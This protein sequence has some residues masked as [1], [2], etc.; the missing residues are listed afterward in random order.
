MNKEILRLAIPNIITNL[1][2]PLVSLVDLALMGRMPSTA[3][4]LAMGFGTV[5][6]NFIYWAFGFLRMGTTGMVSQAYGKSDNNTS[7]D[8]LIKGLSIAF[9][10][11]LLMI[12]FQYPLKE[13]ALFLI[14]PES[15][16]VAPLSTYFNYRI[17]AAPATISLFVI[18]GWL[19]GMQNAKWAMIL[20]LTVNGI[21]AVL[22]F[23]LVHYFKLNIAGVAIGKVIAQYSGLLIAILIFKSKYELN[24]QLSD[25]RRILKSKGWRSFISV[26]SDILIRTLCLIFTMSFFKTKAGN[27]DPILGA[28]NILLLEFISISAYGIDGFAFA[29][30]ALSG[31][32]FGLG[33]K[34]SFMKSVKV[35]MKWGLGIAVLLSIVFVFFG[36]ELLFVLTNQKEVLNAALVY[37]PWLIAAPI[38]NSFAFIWDGIYVGTTTSKAMRNT[39]IFSTFVIFL[40]AFFI[41]DH[42]LNNHGIWLAFSLFMLSRGVFQSF[43]AKSYIFNRL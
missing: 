35:A 28:A 2:V 10:A 37:L 19:L 5:I 14:N 20:A 34:E 13:A 21:N 26:N 32:Y 15:E 40:P 43:L 29:A 4:I 9:V 38:I 16:V 12:L 25:F 18:S 23:V 24:I 33:K 17:F 6:F 11:G 3:Y 7:R 8:L 39:M 22:S 36:E 42:Y 31:K 30:E 41:G 27:V 1:S